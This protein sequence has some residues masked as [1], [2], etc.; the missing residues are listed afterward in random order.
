MLMYGFGPQR[1]W[2]K[3]REVKYFVVKKHS[4]LQQK[5]FENENFLCRVLEF[6]AALLDETSVALDARINQIRGRRKEN[7]MKTYAKFSVAAAAL[8]LLGIAASQMRGDDGKH[9]G[10]WKTIVI[11]LAEDA[12]TEA[13]I[14][15][16]GADAEL[17]R[18]YTFI[19]NGKLYPG[20]TIPAGD[21]LDIDS[22]T[23]S[24]GTWLTR[25]TFNVDVSQI[26]AG[27]HPALSS[28]EYYL[29]SPTGVS[30][31][32]EALFSE[33]PEFGATTH[34][35]VLGGT[36]RYRGVVGE[37]QE[38]TLGNNSTGFANKRY[39]FTIRTPE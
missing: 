36:G 30:D 27:A 16:N 23:G 34:R 14:K 18:G 37:V 11:D 7:K 29:F 3:F 6:K 25:G 15:V 20:G 1:R 4:N 22:L 9:A 21:G 35:V 28:T 13:H 32:E 19:V 39:T 31:G 5:F 33:G 17:K 38:E 12:R 26:F 8:A 2:R 24:I 10:S